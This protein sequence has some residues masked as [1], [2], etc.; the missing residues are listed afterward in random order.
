MIY[1]F[2]ERIGN[3][4]L[5]CGRKQQM[6]LLMNWA[7]TIPRKIAKSRA[8]L[9][10]GGTPF[11]F[12]GLA[13]GGYCSAYPP[14]ATVFWWKATQYPPY[15]CPAQSGKPKI[16][17]AYGD[18][19]FETVF[20]RESDRYLLMIKSVSNSCAFIHLNRNLGGVPNEG[21]S[22]NPLFLTSQFIS[23]PQVNW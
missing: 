23:C 19:Q 10:Q 18:I 4:S 2:E 20:N 22:L 13:D 16:P 11:D 12:K 7:N 8:L 3:P 5:F 15:I 17:Y 6:E 14:S 21:V 1:A 9:G